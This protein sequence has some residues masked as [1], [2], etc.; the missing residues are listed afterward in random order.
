MTAPRP[1]IR[2]GTKRAGKLGDV[3]G[4]HAREERGAPH[5]GREPGRGG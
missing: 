2:K 4:Q 1:G 5:C 3:E